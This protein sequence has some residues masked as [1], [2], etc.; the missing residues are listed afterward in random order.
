MK[1]TILLDY[2]DTANPKFTGNMTALGGKIES[3]YFGDLFAETE[4]C[5]WCG[6]ADNSTADGMWICNKCGA[7]VDKRET[8]K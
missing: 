4:P 5:G 1:V 3:V 2:P 7:S 6:S 8:A